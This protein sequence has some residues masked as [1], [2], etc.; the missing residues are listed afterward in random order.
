MANTR[1][2]WFSFNFLQLLA[3]LD[4]FLI[5]TLTP[6]APDELRI[7]IKKM[8]GSETWLLAAVTPQVC[9]TLFGLSVILL[10]VLGYIGRSRIWGISLILTMLIA[11]A[12]FAYRSSLLGPPDIR[13][14][15]GAFQVSFGVSLLAFPLIWIGTV[16]PKITPQLSPEPVD[17]EARVDAEQ[18]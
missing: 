18:R 8:Y 14:F 16:L 11:A 13:D 2:S 10:P 7:D 5:M 6:F 15:A 17:I 12:T 3:C 9:M 4:I 1:P